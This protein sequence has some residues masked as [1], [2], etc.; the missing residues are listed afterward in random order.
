MNRLLTFGIGALALVGTPAFAQDEDDWTGPYVGVQ[1]GITRANSATDV[2]LGGAWSSESAALRDFVT[3][4]ADARQRDHDANTGVQLGYNYQTGSI[5]LGAEVEFTA[6]NGSQTVSRGPLRY[7][8]VA[9]LT[10]TFTNTVDP[11]HMTA[12]KAKVG[13]AAGSTLFYAEGGW[14]W[15]KASFATTISSSNN[16][17]KAGATTKTLNGWIVGGG[18]EQKFGDNLSARLSYNYTDQGAVTYA[19]SYRPGSSF[20]T[21]AYSE[22]ATQNLR[23]HLVRLG[24]NYRF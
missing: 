19:T 23:L 15:T 1:A 17:L 16:Y 9:N 21:P 20:T 13:A 2:S 3:T 10:Y 5:V 24:L 12:V 8:P 11:K 7:T 4:N 18:V 14:A 22:T 6:L